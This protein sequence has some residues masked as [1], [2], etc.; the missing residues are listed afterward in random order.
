CHYPLSTIIPAT[1]RR[2]NRS[3]RSA[4]SSDLLLIGTFHESDLQV[5][6]CVHRDS[7][8]NQHDCASTC[9]RCKSYNTV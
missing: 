1:Q 7:Y 4:D 8:K 2:S 9:N 3:F 6:Y 5:V